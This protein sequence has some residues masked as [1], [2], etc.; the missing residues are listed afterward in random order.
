MFGI[1]VGSIQAAFFFAE[2]FL[3]IFAAPAGGWAKHR[4]KYLIAVAVVSVV[5]I[6]GMVAPRRYVPDILYLASPWGL[7]F[8]Y[9][10]FA[11]GQLLTSYLWMRIGVFTLRDAGILLFFIVFALFNWGKAVAYSQNF[12]SEHYTITTHSAVIDGVALVRTSAAGFIVAVDGK[13]GFFPSGE[14]RQVE[15][16]KDVEK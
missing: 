10:L 7:A 2:Q 6:I 4:K 8:G 11:I 1:I 3:R 15:A 14:I 13:I 12:S 16:E 9:S 5:F